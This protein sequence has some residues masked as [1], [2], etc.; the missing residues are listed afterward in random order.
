MFPIVKKSFDSVKSRSR[1]RYFNYSL[2]NTISKRYLKTLVPWINANN[3]NISA[4]NGGDGCFFTDSNNNKI[5]DFTSG[6]MVVN[7][8]HNNL[9][10]NKA[11]KTYID[12]G[13]LYAPPNIL[14]DTREILSN[15]IVDKAPKSWD[16]Q[17]KVFYTN[18]GADANESAIFICL[19]YFAKQG[20]LKKKRILSFKHSFHGGSSYISSL[21]GGDSRKEYKVNHY[22]VKQDSILPNPIISEEDTQ[23]LSSLEKIEYIFKEHHEEIA[24]ILVE[25]SSGTAGIYVYPDG[26]YKK[27]ERLAKKYNI[28]IIVDEV[29]SGYGRTGKF[30]ASEHYNAEPDLITMAKGLTNGTVPMGAVLINEKLYKQYDNNMMATG[31]TYSGHPLACAVANETIDIF[32]DSDILSNVIIVEDFIKKELQLIKAK[33][34]HLVK[35]VRGLGAL[36]CIELYEDVDLLKI[37]KSFS[38]NFMFCY[39]RNQ[40][41]FIAPPLIIN[42]KELRLGFDIIHKSLNNY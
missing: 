6:L 41:I 27:L 30:F 5:I 3:S 25:G 18:G 4:I 35:D 2:N 22:D 24:A 34:S 33:Y 11:L 36:Q 17:G 39:S 28:L 13:L 10:L 14:L 15:K 16:K 23:G 19:D 32:N 12:K 7:L 40:K 20:L 8:G 42:E 21:V 37:S 9:R 1:S 38:D 31:L 29:M 26:Y